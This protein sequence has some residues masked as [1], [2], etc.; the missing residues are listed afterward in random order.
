VRDGK[1]VTIFIYSRCATGGRRA[2][3]MFD[4]TG[5]DLVERKITI[6]TW[7]CDWWKNI[8]RDV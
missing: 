7:M 2:I 8:I 6:L 4:L 1:N 5:G 3:V